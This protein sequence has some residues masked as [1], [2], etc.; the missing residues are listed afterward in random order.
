MSK[1]ICACLVF[2]M[3]S[4]S[5]S[6][7]QNQVPKL[8]SFSLQPIS[9]EALKDLKQRKL[10]KRWLLVLWS[11]DCPACFKELKLIQAIQ[12]TEKSTA[13][14]IVFINTDDNRDI[15]FERKQI[16]AFYNMQPYEN[17]YFVDG[18][19]DKNRYQIDPNWYGELPRSY[20]VNKAGKFQGKS[21]LLGEESIKTWL[22]ND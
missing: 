8:K 18:Q 11:L 20:F 12:E 10:G 19:A 16:L 4:C 7:A 5:V 6:Q 14:N 2:F 1:F 17:F 15:Q 9:D 21:G 3:M 13:L 22:L